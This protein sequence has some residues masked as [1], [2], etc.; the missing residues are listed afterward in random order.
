[1]KLQTRA[2]PKDKEQIK[3]INECERDKTRVTI[4][5]EVEI[6]GEG[7]KRKMKKSLFLGIF[8]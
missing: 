3:E 2:Y 7:A 6:R 4:E 8:K 5:R 1:M